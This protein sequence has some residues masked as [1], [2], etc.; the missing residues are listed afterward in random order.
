MSK[1]WMSVLGLVGWSMVSVGC[2]D[3]LPGKVEAGGPQPEALELLSASAE[4]HGGDAAFA[5]IRQ[6]VVDY[7]GQWLNNV[8]KLQP[9]LVDRGYRGSSR[10]WIVY[11]P[12]RGVNDPYWPVVK[13]VHTGPDGE[14]VVQWPAGAGQEVVARGPAGDGDGAGGTRGASV[15]YDGQLPSQYRKQPAEGSGGKAKGEEGDAEPLD[16]DQG[17]GV[18]DEVAQEAAAMVAEAYRMFL[19]GPFYFT[20]RDRSAASQVAPRETAGGSAERRGMLLELPVQDNRPMSRLTA[21]MS[22]PTTVGG[23]VCDQVLVELR[24]GFGVSPVDRVQVAIDR[25]TKYVRR[26]RFSLDG[27][28]ETRGATAEVE[29]SGFREVDGIVFPT[30]FLEIVVHPIDREVHRW[31]AKDIGLTRFE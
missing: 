7:D 9:E 14:K 16:P 23:A 22:K 18:G 30:E 26:V 17:P 3:P 25:Q 10:E 24:P 21:V 15:F 2:I 8:W 28:R 31:S 13:Q 20:Q 1:L 19:T 6:I 4:A 27:F 11:P 5:G 12:F 29:L